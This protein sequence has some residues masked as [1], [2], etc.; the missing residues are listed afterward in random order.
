LRRLLSYVAVVE[1]AARAFQSALM[2]HVQK[3]PGRV[4][5]ISETTPRLISEVFSTPLGT[6]EINEQFVPIRDVAG[7]HI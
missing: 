2:L 1:N 7:S 3:Y 5:P 4:K 6:M